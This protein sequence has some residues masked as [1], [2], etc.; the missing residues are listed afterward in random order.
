M[1]LFPDMVS[2]PRSG[3][4]PRAG[5]GETPAALKQYFTPAWACEA[6]W[7]AHFADVTGERDLVW[8]PCTGPG[9]MLAA[10]PDHVPAIGTEIDPELARIAERQ[11]GRRVIVGDFCEV[12]LPEGI[13]AVFGNPPFELSLVERLLAR[14]AGMLPD[15]SKCGL[16]LP[17]YFFQTS[18]TVVRLNAKWTISSEM[19]PR[20]LFK[21]PTQ[22]VKP[23]VFAVFQ[24]DNAPR[25]IGFRL[26]KETQ[27]IG[28]LPEARQRMLAER[29]DGPRSVWRE[30]LRAVLAELGGTAS[31]QTIYR[32]L[33][34]RRPTDNPW[35]KE[36]IRKVARETKHFRCVGEGVYALPAAA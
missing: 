25:L 28:E 33:E 15:G 17:A 22:M 3:G 12:A 6:L 29:I 36:Q 23:L 11:T 18:G 24:R 1:E 34:G 20:D 30:A 31:L 2:L 10:I 14:C 8:E 21:W 7:D 27:E 5:P 35:W 19:L 9:R 16:I 26:Y 4:V 13:S 32:A